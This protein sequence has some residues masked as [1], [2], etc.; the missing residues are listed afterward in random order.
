MFG[1]NHTLRL[2]PLETILIK[3]H[4]YIDPHEA[5]RIIHCFME[6]S[7]LVVNAFNNGTSASNCCVQ[8]S[9]LWPQ[10][11][12]A[13]GLC[14][15]DRDYMLS[16][17]RRRLI[18]RLWKFSRHHLSC[19]PGRNG[20]SPLQL[21]QWVPGEVLR[22][23]LDMLDFWNLNDPRMADV[24]LAGAGARTPLGRELAQRRE[25]WGRRTRRAVDHMME[26]VRQIEQRVGGECSNRLETIAEPGVDAGGECGICYE[27]DGEMVRVHTCGHVFCGDCLEG[28]V[29]GGVG[30]THACPMCRTPFT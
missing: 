27:D 1:S 6:L 19:G 30:A 2:H 23:G 20:L 18:R 28:W 7:T 9:P 25:E 26:V 3:P 17:D 29:H 22:V 5:G 13:S 21:Q 14:N 16:I 4:V 15:D 10:I 12:A 24:V 8:V 11:V